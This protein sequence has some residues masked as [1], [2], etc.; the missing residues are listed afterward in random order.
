MNE[1]QYEWCLSQLST[2]D[3]MDRQAQVANMVR[4]YGRKIGKTEEEI[5]ADIQK[6]FV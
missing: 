4:F 5:R 3:D 2:Y 6:H 1:K